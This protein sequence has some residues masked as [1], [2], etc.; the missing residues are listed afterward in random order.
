MWSAFKSDLLDF[1]NTITEDT[2]KTLASAIGEN[3][4]ADQTQVRRDQTHRDKSD[5][6]LIIER[7][8]L[9]SL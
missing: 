3:E 8:L 1:V 5:Q 7:K 6:P 4:D 2:S 9:E